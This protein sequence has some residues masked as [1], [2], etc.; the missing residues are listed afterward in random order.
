[1]KSS[2]QQLIVNIRPAATRHTGRKYNE[3]RAMRH[4]PRRNMQTPCSA[5]VFPDTTGPEA[6]AQERDPRPAPERLVTITVAG[7]LLGHQFA[8][9]AYRLIIM[10]SRGGRDDAD[11]N[12]HSVNCAP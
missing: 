3:N 2:P 4:P 5:E 12:T 6:Y 1:M 11:D 10:S 7:G 9:S 8:T